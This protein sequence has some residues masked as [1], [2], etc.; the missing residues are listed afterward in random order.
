MVYLKKLCCTGERINYVTLSD[1]RVTWNQVFV[2]SFEVFSKQL[3]E[4][5]S[6]TALSL[7]LWL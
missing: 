3:F 7:A 1:M 4:L 2:G 6:I 5:E